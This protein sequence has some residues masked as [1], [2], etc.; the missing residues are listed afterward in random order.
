MKAIVRE[1]NGE[2][3]AAV[4]GTPSVRFLFPVRLLKQSEGRFVVG[5]EPESHVSFHIS[6]SRADSAALTFGSR[7][8][9]LART[10]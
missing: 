4:S 8:I 3:E 10:N 9:Q 2:L 1:A 5:W 7:S 6:G